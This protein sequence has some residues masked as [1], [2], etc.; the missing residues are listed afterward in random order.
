MDFFTRDSDTICAV[1]T[2]HGRGGISVV[3]VS[4]PASDKIVRLCCPFLPS[5]LESH[6]VFYGHLRSKKNETIDEVLVTYFEKGRSFTGDQVFEISCH[7]SPLICEEI[8]QTLI[9]HGARPAG[10]GEFT[11]RAFMNGRLDL[12]Q[13]EGVLEVIESQTT[14]QKKM[15]LRQLGGRYSQKLQALEDQL[16]RILAH[17]EADIDFSTEDLET[18]PRSEVILQLT[19]ISRD[20]EAFLYSYEVGR[21]IRDGLH[22][23]L[24]GS[25]NVGKS[26]LFN[27]LVGEE[28]AIVTP[29]AGTTRDVLSEDVVERGFKFS[30]FDTAGIRKNSEDLIEKMGM[31]RSREK[32]RE[33]DCLLFVLDSTRPISSDEV[34]LLSEISQNRLVFV[35]NKVDLLGVH[36]WEK[37]PLAESL[38][39]QTGIFFKDGKTPF[40]LEECK[41]IGLSAK[42][43]S[44][45]SLIFDHLLG[46]ISLES[47]PLDD[48][49]VTSSRHFEALSSA[50]SS[51]S[52]A[53]DSLRMN[54][55]LEFIALELKESLLKIQ[56]ILGISYDDQILDRVFKEFCLGK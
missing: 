36:G 44:S 15:A 47:R 24:L 28:R 26:T 30:F 1:S 45:R 50:R 37:S 29:V 18:L 12:A 52:Q 17:V 11:Y 39:N 55:S 21:K 48:L 56:S 49:V 6:R 46:L 54:R 22:V 33:A 9:S 34:S 40:K 7:G 16:T 13:A 38:R 31:D 14:E 51:V 32:S 27:S 41:V 35:F 19:E 20:L 3:R 8:L 25:P 10:R 43:F 23:V 2:P 4:G 42:E 5:N 53:L